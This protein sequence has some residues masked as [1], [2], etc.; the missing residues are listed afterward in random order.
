MEFCVDVRISSVPLV[1]ADWHRP[2]AAVHGNIGRT[3]VAFRRILPA[4]LA[5]GRWNAIFTRIALNFWHACSATCKLHNV[6]VL[7]AAICWITIMTT[8][9]KRQ[10]S[11]RVLGGK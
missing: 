7:Q 5:S 3:S 11:R 1:Q 6:L 10:P 9:A 8:T 4:E 2:A